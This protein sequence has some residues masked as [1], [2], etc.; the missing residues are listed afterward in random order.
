[1]VRIR[2]IILGRR[3]CMNWYRTVAVTDD[4]ILLILR[5]VWLWRF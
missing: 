4:K 1:M 2:V 3:F 5:L